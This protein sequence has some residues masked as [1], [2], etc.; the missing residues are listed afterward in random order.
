MVRRRERLELVRELGGDA[1]FADPKRLVAEARAR[2]LYS[3]ATSDSDIECVLRRT[4]TK[5]HRE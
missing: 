2:G 1:V 3:P 4:W 5:R